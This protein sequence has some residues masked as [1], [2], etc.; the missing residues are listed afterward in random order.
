[1]A[2][3]RRP[4]TARIR[5]LASRTN[6][7]LS[8]PLLLAAHSTDLLVFFNELILGGAPCRDHGIEFLGGGPHGFDLCLAASLLRGNV[9][10]E[11][12]AMTG[13]RERAPA[14]QVSREVLTELAHADLFCLHGCVPCVHNTMI[15]VAAQTPPDNGV[16]PPVT[17]VP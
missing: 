5:M 11:G 17:R 12:F 2:R 1:M 10:A 15:G 8:I 3:T 4:S 9:E 14:L 7:L 13:D 16:H 6:D